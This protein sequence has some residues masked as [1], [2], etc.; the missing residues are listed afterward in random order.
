MRTLC[1]ATNT[2]PNTGS[3]PLFLSLTTSTTTTIDTFW[4]LSSI[5]ERILPEYYTKT[6]VGSV[7]DQKV[8]LH[9]FQ[10]HL[11][12]LSRHLKSIDVDIQ[13][14]S[15][16]WFVCLYLSSLPLTSAGRVLDCFFYLGPRFLFQLGLALLKFH[17]E[18]ILASRDD[19]EVLQILKIGF[20]K[21]S[22]DP[23][24]GADGDQPPPA[25]PVI[26]QTESA[27]PAPS[28]APPRRKVLT[29][30]LKMA[31]D[32]YGFLT[33]STIEDLRKKFRIT[34]WFSFFFF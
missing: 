20:S 14:V 27:L 23:P 1:F 9:L 4:V 28:P 7:I 34:Y 8:F 22:D 17:E 32:D 29:E 24:A 21:I 10:T 31:V 2:H 26:P 3:S 13:L 33:T 19:D 5:C 6:M 16:P 18:V 11:P 25:S 12:H 15:V 30:V